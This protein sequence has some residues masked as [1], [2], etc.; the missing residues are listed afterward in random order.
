M[1]GTNEAYARVRK[2]LSQTNTGKIEYPSGTNSRGSGGR[3]HHAE[4]E[5]V[6]RENHARGDMVGAKKKNSSVGDS[7]SALGRGG[8]TM[9]PHFG[10]PQGGREM[11]ARRNAIAQARGEN[12]KAGDM[13]G[14]EEHG[15]GDR[16]GNMARRAAKAAPGVMR[17]AGKAMNTAGSA[18]Q[19]AAK[20]A[21][22]A[23]RQAGNA[24]KNA[25]PPRPMYRRGGRT[26]NEE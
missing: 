24:A 5:M 19:G 11:G 12:H 25:M 23:M 21:P 6:G 3:E 17:K 16:V 20:A 8:S 9:K 4:G 10:A 7:G 15:F 14:R 22:G 1:I 13:V 18:M 26:D 2:M